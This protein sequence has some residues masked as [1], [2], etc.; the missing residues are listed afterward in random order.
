MLIEADDSADEI[1]SHIEA[2]PIVLCHRDFWITNIFYKDGKIILIDWD[3]AGWGYVGEDIKSLIADE[4]DVDHMLLYYQKCI[5]AYY[6][7]FSEYADLSHI[8]RHCIREM[9]LAHYGYRLV[10]WYIDAKA[11]DKKHCKLALCKKSTK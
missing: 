9:I 8:K 11:P 1:W 2:L 4:A 3:T 7:G 10:E 5:P 6:K